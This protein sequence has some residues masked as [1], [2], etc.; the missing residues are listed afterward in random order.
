MKNVNL[1]KMQRCNFFVSSRLVGSFLQS[2]GR[3]W[4]QSHELT[5]KMHTTA[6]T[7]P[8]DQIFHLIDK[9]WTQKKYFP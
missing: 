3:P 1:Y 7:I 4:L 5:F 8:G 9:N 2:H 6:K